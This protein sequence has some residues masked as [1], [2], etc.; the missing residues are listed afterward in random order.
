MVRL[1]YYNERVDREKNGRL[2]GCDPAA[3]LPVE[4]QIPVGATPVQDTIR[5]LIRGELTAAEKA[6][7]FTTEFPKN[8]FTLE[9]ANL[10]NG[11]L[12]LEFAEVPGFTSG[13]SCRVIVLRT[14]IERTAL[15]FPG[16]NEVRFKPDAIF[17]P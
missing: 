1:Y 4:R 3:I 5:L 16:V 8:G 7:G 13:G 11:V 17:E 6:Q 9:G 10:A 12:T 2:E 15:Q 14:A